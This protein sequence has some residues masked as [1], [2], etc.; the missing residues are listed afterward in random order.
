[1][2]WTCC[3][4]LTQRQICSEDSTIMAYPLANKEVIVSGDHHLQRVGIS[5][6]TLTLAPNF[7]SL[8]MVM[9]K[10]KPQLESVHLY[11]LN[12]KKENTG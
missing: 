5:M 10:T 2:M 6:G 8:F 9:L 1:M 7:T 3:P 12:S 11:M 4:L